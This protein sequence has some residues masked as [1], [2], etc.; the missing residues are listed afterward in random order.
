MDDVVESFLGGL[1]FIQHGCMRCGS[2]LV[3]VSMLEAILLILLL[4][5]SD[6]VLRSGR[7]HVCPM[8]EWRIWR[9]IRFF[10]QRSDMPLVWDISRVRSLRSRVLMRRKEYSALRVERT[11]TG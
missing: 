11:N 4:A 6:C 5:F 2:Y 10:R 7:W 3:G 8:L 1:S 9:F